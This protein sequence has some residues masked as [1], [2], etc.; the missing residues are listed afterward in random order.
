MFACEQAVDDS[1]GFA[2]TVGDQ[3]AQ[4]LALARRGIVVGDDTPLNIQ[5]RHGDV[6]VFQHRATNAHLRSALRRFAE[7]ALRWWL[8]ELP[9]EKRRQQRLGGGDAKEVLAAHRVGRKRRHH[10]C[11]R[12]LPA[13]AEYD[14]ARLQAVQRFA[15]G[16]IG[17][18]QRRPVDAGLG[19]LIA[20]LQHLDMS[21]GTDIVCTG[22]NPPSERVPTLY[23]G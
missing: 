8:V 11:Q 12:A 4:Q 22:I 19:I 6:R 9:G 5:R 14:L 23:F 16:Q 21:L 15:T 3:L 10:A 18:Y 1:G 7:I 17:A 2:L 20:G 13:R